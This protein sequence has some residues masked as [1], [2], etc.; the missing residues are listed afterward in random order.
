MNRDGTMTR[1]SHLMLPICLVGLAIAG[2]SDAQDAP[3]AL[4]LSCAACHGTDGKSP[5]AIPTLAG[6]PA[7]ELKEALAGFKAGTR[8]AT[9][10]NRLAKGYTDQEIDALAGYF[11]RHK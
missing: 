4:A 1:R 8:P 2:P 9:V 3:T 5:G 10:M 6:R 7:K 11:S